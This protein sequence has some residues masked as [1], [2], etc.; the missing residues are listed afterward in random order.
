MKNNTIDSRLLLARVA[1]ENSL[2]NKSILDALSVF[3]YNSKKLKEGMALLE[4]AEQKHTQQK[5]E[6]GSSLMQ[7]MN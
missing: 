5:K 7:R 6:Y 1:I 4:D 2:N 3:G